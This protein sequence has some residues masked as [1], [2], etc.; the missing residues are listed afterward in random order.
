MPTK[1]IRRSIRKR[2]ASNHDS[3][4]KLWPYQ[5]GKR[6]ALEDEIPHLEST[7]IDEAEPLSPE[8]SEEL[9]A[10]LNQVLHTLRGCDEVAKRISTSLDH[11]SNKTEFVSAAYRELLSP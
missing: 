9:D 11:V 1:A 2:R 8:E 3:R 6:Y 7:A 5:R 10:L 4:R